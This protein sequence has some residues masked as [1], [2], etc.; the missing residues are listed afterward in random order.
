MGR[1]FTSSSA[2]A[3]GPSQLVGGLHL[4]LQLHSLSLWPPTYCASVA[5]AGHTLAPR[6]HTVTRT[7][8][9]GSTSMPSIGHVQRSTLTCGLTAPTSELS[10]RQSR[11]E[12]VAERGST[13][14]KRACR[15]NA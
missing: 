8:S 13:G 15:G 7:S 5:L 9:S 2:C 1:G 6:L 12:L 3:G 10:P 11:A 4:V 14:R